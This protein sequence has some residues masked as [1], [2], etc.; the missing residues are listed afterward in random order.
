MKNVIF[1]QTIIALVLS[2]LFDEILCGIAFINVLIF[3]AFCKSRCQYQND[4]FVRKQK[5]SEVS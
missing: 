5:Y 2:R 4:G 1:S 3:I